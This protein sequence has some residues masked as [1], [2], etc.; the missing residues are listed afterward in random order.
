MRVF[1]TCIIALIFCTTVLNAQEKETTTGQRLGLTAALQNSQMDIMLP[2]FLADEVALAPSV[3]FSSVGDKFS[4]FGL[5][6]GGRFY[7]NR[8]RVSPFVSV[9]FGVLISSPK[10]SDS[11]TD[12]VTGLGGGGEYFISRY[13]SLGVEAQLNISK[14]SENSNRFGNPGGT[15]LNTASAIFATVYF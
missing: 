4:D 1:T 6:L 11:M 2:I 7:V 3:G 15:N 12:I 5:G 9:R 13:F 8:G 10:D 14:S